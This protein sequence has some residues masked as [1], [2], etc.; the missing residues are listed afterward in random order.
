M[1]HVLVLLLG[2]LCIIETAFWRFQN[3]HSVHRVHNM[4]ILSDWAPN[5]PGHGFTF[6]R[7]H[8]CAIQRS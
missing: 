1:V 3:V 2:F 5:R 6:V 8:T 7:L 4:Y